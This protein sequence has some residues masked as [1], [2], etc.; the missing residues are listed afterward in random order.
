MSTITDDDNGAYVKTRNTTKLYC[1]W[2]MKQK[3]FVKKTENFFRMLNSLIIHMKENIFR[4]TRH[5]AKTKL[6]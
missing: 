6:L 2:K 5:F 4:L 3:V 1:R